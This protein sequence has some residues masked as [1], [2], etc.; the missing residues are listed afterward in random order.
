[1]MEKFKKM[2]SALLL[3]S[4]LF[5]ALPV[6]TYASSEFH[7][8]WLT[9]NYDE[10]RAFNNR[11][12]VVRKGNKLG[13]I[14]KTGKE[15][16]PLIYNTIV[17]RKEGFLKVEKDG[18]HGLVNNKGNF[19]V[20]LIYDWID[21]YSEGLAR[22]YIGNKFGYIDITG[23][24]IV[25][26]IYDGGGDF[27]EG[28]ALV[29]KKVSNG[30][31]G[32]R[33]GFID[34]TGKEVIKLQYYF[35]HDFSEGLAWVGN[36]DVKYGAIDKKGNV[37]IPF[38]YNQNVREFSEGL[39]LV[40]AMTQNGEAF[41]YINQ[42]GGIV[43]PATWDGGQDCKDGLVWVNAAYVYG[44]YDRNGKAINP[45]GW[46]DMT[47]K[48]EDG[49]IRVG[50]FGNYTYIDTTGKEI[51][52]LA[53]MGEFNEG[54]A[55][56][57]AKTEM[58]YGYIDRTG[59]V[60]IPIIYDTVYNF[61]EG[62]ALVRAG[63]KY[64]F[65][66][67]TGNIAID[68]SYPRADS[69]ENGY[70]QVRKGLNFGMIDK[71]GK[72]VLP[73]IYDA[74]S[75]FKEGY[76][77][78]REDE[79]NR[80][81]IIDSNAKIVVEPKY[82]SIT[83]FSE[84]LAIVTLEGKTGIMESPDSYIYD[85]AKEVIAQPTATKVLVNDKIVPFEAYNIGGSNYFKLRDLALIL[86]G[87]EKQFNVSRDENRNEINLIS[88]SVYKANGQEMSK[89]DGIKKIA[90]LN[91][92]GIYKDGTKLMIV[93]YNISGNNYFKLR[94]IG[95]AMNFGVT[96]DEKTSTIRIDTVKEYNE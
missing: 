91:A 14:N 39:A 17:T 62:L 63:D 94:D 54:L 22:V 68:L 57:R 8:T 78:I 83:D 43:I 92:S 40:Q 50:Y 53:D 41:G 16:V 38:K 72:E 15:I 45:N 11:V 4:I 86:N 23:K 76:A 66:D 13:I 2:I 46:Y 65:I 19:V 80:V 90:I 5:A 56:V 9:N 12:A 33:Y 27:H 93:A 75:H 3:I 82:Y 42:K 47:S 26:L 51:Y 67:K 96:W 6:S 7:V 10:I 61:S 74:I 84:G 44:L 55:I 88:N 60:V 36:K 58:K 59:N 52:P 87:T 24:K 1:M 25:P 85:F 31:M 71:T 89:G 69:F 18:K 37:V 77:T 95:Q 34:K 64:S 20:P 48:L 49:L 81:G 21:E 73:V 30:Y 32:N 79:S 70:A 28:L 29:R 35:A